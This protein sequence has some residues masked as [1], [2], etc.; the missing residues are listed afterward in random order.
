MMSS[1]NFYMYGRRRFFVLPRIRQSRA[2]A[3]EVMWST[4]P[5][6]DSAVGSASKCGVRVES[7]SMGEVTGVQMESK[8]PTCKSFLSGEN[9]CK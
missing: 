3:R 4:I 6:L 5:G 7:K 8:S 1:K 9:V 2:T